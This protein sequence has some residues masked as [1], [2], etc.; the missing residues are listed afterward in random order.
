VIKQIFE[1]DLHKK[2]KGA[3]KI[4][5]IEDSDV[6][7]FVAALFSI[8]NMK[9]TVQASYVSDIKT[10]QAGDNPQSGPMQWWYNGLLE[11]ML[12]PARGDDWSTHESLSGFMEDMWNDVEKIRAKKP[13]GE[14]VNFNDLLRLMRAHSV[15]GNTDPNTTIQSLLSSERIWQ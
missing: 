13:Q 14:G 2:L 7:E 15:E 4:A 3:V 8:L 5:F 6:D 11:K 1:S 9:N 12:A 10:A